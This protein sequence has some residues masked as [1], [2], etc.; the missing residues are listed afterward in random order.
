MSGDMDDWTKCSKHGITYRG[1]WC[2][3]CFPQTA[4]QETPDQVDGPKTA[5]TDRLFYGC[6]IGAGIVIALWFVSEIARLWVDQL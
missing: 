2:P 4:L 1:D 5:M 6:A 3:R